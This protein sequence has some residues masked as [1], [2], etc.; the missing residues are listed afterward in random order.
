M[1]NQVN[2]H[3]GEVTIPLTTPSSKNAVRRNL[4][5]QVQLH[6]MHHM[7]TYQ[8]QTMYPTEDSPS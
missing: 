6:P 4:T 1:Y 8:I 5:V 7:S 2:D 3:R